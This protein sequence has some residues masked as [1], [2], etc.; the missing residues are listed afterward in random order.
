LSLGLFS[1]TSPKMNFVES[2]GSCPWSDYLC[3]DV[4][5]DENFWPLFSLICTFSSCWKY[6]FAHAKNMFLRY[7]I[8]LS[9]HYKNFWGFLLCLT[10]IQ[11]EQNWKIIFWVQRNWILITWMHRN[12]SDVFKMF[13]SSLDSMK[14]DCLYFLD[15]EHR[16]WPTSLAPT[17]CLSY[18]DDFCD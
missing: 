4:W 14:F 5:R 12:F 18:G 17:W 9:C 8:C 6:D 13:R 16:A 1:T 3:C 11:Y 15:L 7:S 2:D 10:L